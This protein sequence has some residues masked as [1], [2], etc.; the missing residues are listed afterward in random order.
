M[1]VALNA[2]VARFVQHQYFRQHRQGRSLLISVEP[3]RL[4]GGEREISVI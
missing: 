3:S 2:H 4:R 1:A